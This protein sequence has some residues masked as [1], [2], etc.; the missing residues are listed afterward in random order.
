[1]TAWREVRNQLGP[2]P[3]ALCASPAGSRAVWPLPWLDDAIVWRPVWQGV[4]HRTPFDP[5]HGFELT[6]ML[7]QHRFDA[8]IIVSAANG[9]ER[10]A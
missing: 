10:P 8:A 2:A 9:R 6:N 1:M 5:S 4:G 3:R 7:R